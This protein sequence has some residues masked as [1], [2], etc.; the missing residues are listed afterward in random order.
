MSQF[1]R[2]EFLK[3]GAVLTLSTFTPNILRAQN[4]GNDKFNWK[5]YE[6]KDVGMSQAGLDG[7]RAAIQKNIDNKVITGA[8]TAVARH[9]KLVWYEAQG[10]SNVETNVPMNK[11]SIFRM[12]SS[13]KHITA[14]AILMMMEAGKLALD[15]KVSRFIP[16]FK[17]PKVALAPPGAKDASQVKIVPADREITIKDL[18]THT[19]GLSSYGE[20]INPGPGSLVNKI[21]RKSDDT[22]AD[23]VP[24]L[25]SAVLD[26]QPGT[27][28]RYSPLDGF[29][30]L[31]HIVEITS[32]KPADEFMRERIF[33]PL[34]MRE[35]YFKLPAEKKARVVGLYGAYKN[36]KWDN[37]KPILPDDPNKYISGAGGLYSTVHDFMQFDEMLLNLGSLNGRRMLKA[38]TVTLMTRNHVGSLFAEWIPFITGGFGFGLGVGIV[39]D[40]QKGA[41]RSVGAFG[42]GG[43]YGTESW[44][45]P[46]PGI[47]AAMFIQMQPAPGN[48]KTDFQQAIS[49]AIVK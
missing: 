25:G 5:I 4:S 44:A 1:T 28:W 37:A 9:N 49:W 30:V 14:V 6:P 31:M 22:L 16:S 26:F 12:A 38:E 20:L 41:G 10:F 33:K 45:D 17:N 34:E 47:A 2:R 39:E 43:A 21:E 18:L 23:Y 24:R 8:V 3:L 36:G 40:P 35:T 7:I 48:V 29:D 32:G 46:K 27:K 42:W 15:D 19:S 11:D 13:T